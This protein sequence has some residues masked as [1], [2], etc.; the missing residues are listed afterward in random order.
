M[1][2]KV[3]IVSLVMLLLAVGCRELPAY[4]K[5]GAPLAKV[6][7]RT[8]YLHEVERLA[9]EGIAGDDSAAFY[10][11]YADRWVARQLK[12]GEAERIF[13]EEELADVDAMVEEYRQSL[14]IRK[15]D[16]H[17]VDLS[18]DTVFTEESVQ[19]YYNAHLEDFRSDR[20]LVKGRIL[21]LPDG[22]RQ[23]KKLLS[24]MRSPSPES[25]KDLKDICTKQN[26]LFEELGAEWIDWDDFLS[27][28]PALRDHDYSS[29]LAS[30]DI[31][32]MRDNHSN[33]YFQLTSVRR[34]GEALPLERVRE[35]IRRILFNQ[36]QGELI[37][38]HERELRD[39]ADERGRVKIYYENETEESE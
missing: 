37:R 30:S 17:Y 33:Y 8:L 27:R 10:R 2:M 5:G 21:R 4:F 29:L 14:L 9:P 1:R 18:I 13:P 34:A 38:S 26:F 31:Q 6:G 32:Q 19:A 36:R 35:T 12:L 20:T 22:E 3:Q 16:Q 23:T 25:R 28:L 7:H 11:M 24:L 15:L 39:A